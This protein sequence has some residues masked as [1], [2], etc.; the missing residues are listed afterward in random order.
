MHST[1]AYKNEWAI[2]SLRKKNLKEALFYAKRI[3]TGIA[4]NVNC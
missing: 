3:R 1:L 2:G 4:G